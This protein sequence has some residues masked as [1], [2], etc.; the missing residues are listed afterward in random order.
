MSNDKILGTGDSVDILKQTS[1]DAPGLKDGENQPDHSLALSR[2]V[3]V[4]SNWP[5]TNKALPPAL[6]RATTKTLFKGTRTERLSSLKPSSEAELS[7]AAASLGK[8]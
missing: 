6:E 1:L 5:A 2:A 8:D 3:P 7:A 4:T